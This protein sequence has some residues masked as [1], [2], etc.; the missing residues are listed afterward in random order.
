ME[1]V[2]SERTIRDA[3]HARGHVGDGHGDEERAE[4]AGAVDRGGADLLDERARAAEARGHEDTGLLR[5]LALQP[6]GQTRVVHGLWEATSAICVVRSLRRTSLRSS[7]VVGSK[8]GTSPAIW[9]ARPDRVEVADAPDARLARQ[10]APPEGTDPRAQRRDG[11]EP[12]DDDT[13][14]HRGAHRTNRPVRM[15]AAR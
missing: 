9:L 3:D 7:T 12:G 2:G 10:Q 6:G 11:A 4:P 8:S 1:I 5:Q 15:V 13:T 14:D